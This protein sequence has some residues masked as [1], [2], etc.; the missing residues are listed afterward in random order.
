MNRSRQRQVKHDGGFQLIKKVSLA[1]YMI[2]TIIIL[3]ID[4]RPESLAKN[5]A[6]LYHQRFCKAA[7]VILEKVNGM[8]E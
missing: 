4:Q 6:A 7:P 1:F 2:Y 8:A 3:I 5:R